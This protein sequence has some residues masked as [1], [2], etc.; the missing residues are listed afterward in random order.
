MATRVLY[1]PDTG[2]VGGTVGLAAW[3]RIGVRPNPLESWSGADLL[4][5]ALHSAA[6][7]LA[8]LDALLR[9]WSR[10]RAQTSFRPLPRS[11]APPPAQL[12]ARLPLAWYVVGVWGGKPC[13]PVH[14][15]QLL[16]W[17]LSDIR[18]A[19]ELSQRNVMRRVLVQ[20]QLGGAAE[21][22]RGELLTRVTPEALPSAER[23][24][25][26][27]LSTVATREFAPATFAR[28]L[29]V[30]RSTLDR[31]MKRSGFVPPS[32]FLQRTRLILAV[33]LRIETGR[34]RAVEGNLGFAS[35]SH[36]SH[37]LRRH[38]QRVLT[39]LERDDPVRSMRNMVGGL[40]LGPRRESRST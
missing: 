5:S 26:A 3:E 19:N 4:G 9:L 27:A 35:P 25:D 32:A 17:G 2:A 7:V 6:L 22:L 34:R 14:V 31:M 10:R 18:S 16:A 38:F 21:R 1:F 40:L 8:D 37:Q 39:D 11:P 12:P 30:S 20:A 36:L 15:Q 29:H 13:N 24:V 23:I 28:R 33:L